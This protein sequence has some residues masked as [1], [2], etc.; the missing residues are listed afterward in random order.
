MAVVIMFL[1]GWLGI[2]ILITWVHDL[3]NKMRM[4]SANCQNLFLLSIVY[5]I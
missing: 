3:M 4:S 5:F 1:D 2:I